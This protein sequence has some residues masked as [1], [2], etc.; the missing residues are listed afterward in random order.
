MPAYEIDEYLK[1]MKTNY[2]LPIGARREIVRRYTPIPVYFD[3]DIPRTREGYYQFLGGD[4]AAVKR[5]LAYAPYAELLWLETSSPDLKQAGFFA[6]VIQQHAPGKHLVYNLSP[7]FK[8]TAKEFVGTKLG[9][10][11]WDLAEKGY[12]A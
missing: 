7:S 12:I 11:V 1:E 4:V 6:K 10:F 2:N 3:W 9:R 5:A 8:W